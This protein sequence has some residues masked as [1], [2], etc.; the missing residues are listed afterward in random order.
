LINVP[1]AGLTL[2]EEMGL[3]KKENRAYFDNSKIMDPQ[4]QEAQYRRAQDSPFAKMEVFFNVQ[5]PPKIKFDDLKTSVS[6]HITYDLLSYDYKTDY[7]KLSPDKVLVP[8][9]IEFNNADLEFKREQGF[10]RAK[11]NVYGIVTS[12][13]GRIAAEWE[14]E[15][16]KDFNDVYFYQGKNKPSEYQRIVA[17]PPG[18]RYRLDLV[19]KDINSKKMG[20]MSVGLNVPKYEGTELQSSTI[21]LADNITKAPMTANQLDQFVIGDMRIVPKVKAEYTPNQ[22]LVP[23]MQ[24]Y[25]MQIDQ[26]TQKPSLDV[27]F[28]LKKNGKPVEELKNTPIN[29]EQ[30]YYGER[31]VLVGKIPL[32]NIAP[33]KYALEIKVQDNISNRSITTSTEFKIKETAPSISSVEP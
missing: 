29:S 33:G 10:N 3:A 2:A 19:M 4:S 1:D 11:V 32:K 21:I 6:T 9:T 14:D 20:S 23:Y 7:I 28:T 27:T 5:R 18:Q 31:V 16:S 12:L 24:I 26:A 22:N 8:I 30:L 13:S 15:I 17:L 25:N